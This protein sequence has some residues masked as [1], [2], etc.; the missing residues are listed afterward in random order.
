MRRYH[1][2]LALYACILVPLASATTYYVRTDGNDAADGL[3]WAT[4]KASPNAGVA[5]ATNIGDLVIVSNGTYTLT[6]TITLTKGITL[7]SADNDYATVLFD[8]GG[9]RR[10]LSL[11]ATATNGLVSGITCTNGAS[12]DG[13][14]ILISG[15]AT[16]SNCLITRCSS[17]GRGGGVRMTSGQLINCIVSSNSAASYGGG[18]DNITGPIAVIGCIISNNTAASGGAGLMLQ[19]SQ[20]NTVTGCTFYGNGS[21]EAVLIY[22]SAVAQIKNCSFFNNEGRALA[23]DYAP[24]VSNCVF[25]GN[26]GGGIALTYASL[27]VDCSF[28]SNRVSGNGGGFVLAANQIADRCV[29][30]HNYAT[31]SGGGVH[32]SGGIARNLLIAGNEV[33]SSGYGGGIRAITSA[34]AQIENCSIVGNKAA[35][36]S[37]GGGIFFQNSGAAVTNCIVTY[38]ID[39]G[40]SSNYF[41]FTGGA[42]LFAYSSTMPAPSGGADGGNNLAL[43]PLFMN[44]GSGFGTNYIPGDL[45]LQGESSCK[46]S[47]TNLEWMTLALDLGRKPRI[48]GNRVDRGAYE[49]LQNLSGIL[50]Q[51][52]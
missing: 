45:T 11:A 5:A 52:Q 33:G 51:V 36:S 40:T 38:N 20:T 7:Q 47:G 17:P 4:A 9:V 28:I 37:R 19:T 44:T 39:G 26:R 50:I 2:G 27:I 16:V 49:L 18:V 29:V 12:T 42:M 14:G 6:N 10:C 15:Q 8:G 25:I 3:T 22:A 35:S 13:G 48:I 23:G 32:M 41:E 31:L 43:N 21:V 46:N 24:I 34:K 1:A 30:L